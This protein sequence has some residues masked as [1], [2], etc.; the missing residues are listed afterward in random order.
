MEPSQK[1]AFEDCEAALAIVIDVADIVVTFDDRL[2]LE[3]HPEDGQ[4]RLRFRNG[5][6]QETLLTHVS[7]ADAE[8]VVRQQAER[9]DDWRVVYQGPL[10]KREL[11]AAMN[12]AF[13]TWYREAVANIGRRRNP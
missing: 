10:D 8:I 3:P 1:D 7:R 11:R 13:A 9:R 5:A 2:S 4:L 12:L 6:H